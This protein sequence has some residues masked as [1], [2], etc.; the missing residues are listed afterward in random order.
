VSGGVSGHNALKINGWILSSDVGCAFMCVDGLAHYYAQT[1]DQRI[2][3]FLD[4][5]ID[6]FMKVDP[7]SLGFQ[8]HTTL[9]CIRGILKLY[10]ATGDEKYKNHAIS[11]FST[12]LKDGMTLTYANYLYFFKNCFRNFL[13]TLAKFI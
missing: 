2:K 12:Y 6:L 10:K 8:T 9:T 1:K 13:K 5:V 4:K 3:I 11:R 7:V